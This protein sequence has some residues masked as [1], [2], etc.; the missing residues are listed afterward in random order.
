MEKL[1]TL[2]YNLQIIHSNLSF[3]PYK[4]IPTQSRNIPQKENSDTLYKYLSDGQKRYSQGSS[5]IETE[6]STWVR[7]F[8]NLLEDFVKRIRRFYADDSLRIHR[9]LIYWEVQTFEIIEKLSSGS[10]FRMYF[11]QCL[12]A[13]VRDAVLQKKIGLYSIGHIQDILGDGDIADVINEDEYR[14]N[15]ESFPEYFKKLHTRQCSRLRRILPAD[16]LFTVKIGQILNTYRAISTCT[17]PSEYSQKYIQY[18][19]AN[20]DD[21]WM[22]IS[23]HE[24]KVL[25][26]R[27]RK[28]IKLSGNGKKKEPEIKEFSTFIS[29][30]Y[31]SAKVTAE[32]RKLVKGKKGKKLA[33]VICAARKVGILIKDTV[34]FSTLRKEFDI[35]GA[36]SGYYFYVNS[37]FLREQD[38]HHIMETLVKVFELP[39]EISDDQR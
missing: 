36:E 1:N 38:Y 3:D 16:N 12:I 7:H 30:E 32:I 31:D 26:D 6:L 39:H 37:E 14:K 25:D 28:E 15:A 4:D 33:M 13:K 11:K 5:V 34:P 35:C 20:H 9:E 17:P 29:M 24:V 8:H 22:E 21:F 23:R 18:F 2:F 19:N 10:S 27:I